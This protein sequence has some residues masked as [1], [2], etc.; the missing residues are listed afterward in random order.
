MATLSVGTDTMPLGLS[1]IRFWMSACCLVTVH[2]PSVTWRT[3][4]P[5]LLKVS[6]IDRI[7]ILL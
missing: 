7:R 2:C 1:A 4:T 3:W 6:V 5:Y